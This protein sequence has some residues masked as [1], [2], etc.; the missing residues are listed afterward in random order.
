[1]IMDLYKI[2][3]HWGYDGEINGN[4]KTISHDITL[5]CPQRWL[6]NPRDKSEGLRVGTSSNQMDE[7][8][9]MAMI[10]RGHIPS[11]KLT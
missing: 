2:N 7:F 10:E 9:A 4:T 1:M 6:E 8:A 11:G 5:R 3:H